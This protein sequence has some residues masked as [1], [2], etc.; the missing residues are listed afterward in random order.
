MIIKNIFLT[1][2]NSQ[3]R[4]KKRGEFNSNLESFR[5]KKEQDFIIFCKDKYIAYMLSRGWSLD[6]IYRNWARVSRDYNFCI[7]Q[8]RYDIEGYMFYSIKYFKENIAE[9]K[10]IGTEMC[11]IGIDLANG[12]DRTAVVMVKNK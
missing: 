4:A 2:I 1:K 11:N 8:Y 7:G 9:N 3:R 5:Q 6:A 12:K 10:S